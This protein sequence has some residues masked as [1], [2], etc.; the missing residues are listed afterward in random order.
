MTPRERTVP[1]A[2]LYDRVA[3]RSAECVIA[4]YSTS[5]GWASRLLD[6]PVRTHVRSIYA[7]VRIADEVV[8]DPEP[9]LTVQERSRMLED[10]AAETA[11]ALAGGRSTNLVVQAFAVTARRCGIDA[12][13]IDPFFASMRADL[14][15]AVHDRASLAEYVHGS[16]EVVGLM[17]L[18][19]FLD[20]DEAEYARLAPAASALGAAFQKVNFLRDLAEDHD[21]LGRVYGPGLDPAAFDDARRDL[22][23]DEIEAD[24]AHA[25]TALPHLPS[26][27]RRAVAAAHGLYAELARRLRAT[28]AARIRRARV[29]VPAPRK[30]L[31]LTRAALGV[32]R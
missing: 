26:S 7:L 16:A 4:G 3:Q 17:C 8:D 5:F 13:L 24:L 10:L 32:R 21:Q 28:P 11:R 15:V 23:L 22:L 25:A 19:V 1:A 20:G 29:R 12:A 31:V 30:A 2:T 27:S 9:A 6:E 18:R 14:T